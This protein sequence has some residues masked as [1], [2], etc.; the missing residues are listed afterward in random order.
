MSIPVV[1]ADYGSANFGSV[2]TAF[3]AIGIQAKVA[4]TPAD[5]ADAR[6]AV[7]PGVGHAASAMAHLDGTWLRDG[8]EARHSAERPILGICL[9]AQ[10]MYSWL[11]EAN[12]PGLRWIEGSVRPLPATLQHN[13]GWAALDH[14]RLKGTGLG[15]SLTAAS[16]F[17]FNH[18]FFLPVG[19]AAVE[20]P[21]AL[22]AGVTALVRQ[23][24]LFGVQFHPE[25]SQDSGRLLLRNLME[26]VRGL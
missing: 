19:H 26:V 8:L 14:E 23:G 15:R 11:D 24:H 5:I 1:V 17:Y 18:A 21:L 4:R 16:T 7:L 10:L 9:G 2:V 6:L 20:V 12:A 3:R 22:D 25:K 13:T